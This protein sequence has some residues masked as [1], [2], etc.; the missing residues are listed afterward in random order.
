MLVKFQIQQLALARYRFI[1]QPHINSA[2]LSMPL[3]YLA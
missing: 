2:I 3:I 1:K